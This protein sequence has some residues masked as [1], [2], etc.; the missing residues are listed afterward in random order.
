MI[1]HIVEIQEGELVEGMPWKLVEFAAVSD[2]QEYH[3]RHVQLDKD[4]YWIR[5]GLRAYNEGGFNET[6][7]CVD[8]V[9]D[10]LKGY[11]HLSDTR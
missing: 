4:G 10:Q 6:L 2:D 1:E 8:C 11:G 3:C 9:M 5:L 7:L